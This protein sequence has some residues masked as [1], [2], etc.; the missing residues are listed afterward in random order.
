VELALILPFL[1]TMVL[2]VVDFGRGWHLKTRVEN[3]ARE[4]VMTAQYQPGFISTGCNGSANVR[5]AV[6]REDKNLAL[7]V[8]DIR[9]NVTGTSGNQATLT[10]GCVSTGA[11]GD[12][13]EVVVEAPLQVFSPFLGVMY[14]DGEMD[15]TGSAHAAVVK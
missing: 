10:S 15:V 8:T 5:D 14:P 7:I 2:T 11:N 9:V 4:G 1:A 6:N 12:E 13:V 3:A